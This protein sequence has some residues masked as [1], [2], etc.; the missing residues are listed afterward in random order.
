ME[1]SSSTGT[2]PSSSEEELLEDEL[3]PEEELDAAETVTLQVADAPLLAVT[4]IVTVPFPLA[5]TIP[6]ESTVAIS[7]LSVFQL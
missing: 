1:I 5:V 6:L 4:V 7:P 3:L 2:I